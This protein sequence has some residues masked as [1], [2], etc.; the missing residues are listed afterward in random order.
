MGIAIAIVAA[1]AAGIIG[2]A[3]RK[4]DQVQYQ[5]RTTVQAPPDAILP[6]IVDFRRWTSWSPWERLDPNMKKT[7][8]G[9]AEGTG[10][11][12]AWEGDRKVGSGRMEITDVESPSR[13]AIKLDFIKPFRV[14]NITTFTLTPVNDG[15]EVTW[16]MTGPNPFISKVFG[17]FM[18]MDAM[19][20]RDFDA[21]LASLKF[22]VEQQGSH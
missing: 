1:L 12:Y 18:D 6:F 17:M 11:T 5:R 8:G 4:P 16:T 21:G 3:A 20:G 9:A 22:V 14:S 15:T 19:I 2:L 7:Y 13:V 10:A